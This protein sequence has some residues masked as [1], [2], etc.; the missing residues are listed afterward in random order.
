MN[1]RNSTAGSVTHTLL[2]NTSKSLLENAVYSLVNDLPG[3]PVNRQLTLARKAM[4]HLMSVCPEL[5]YPLD[6]LHQNEL[7]ALFLEGLPIFTGPNAKCCY[8]VTSLMVGSVIGTAYQFEQQHEGALVAAL[9]PEAGSKENTNTTPEHFGWHTD[10]A[11]FL[12]VFRVQ[13]I[14]LTGEINECGAQTGFAP[15]SDLMSQLTRAQVALLSKPIFLFKT[16]ISFAGIDD[17]N[18][19]SEPKSV[20]YQMNSGKTGIQTP[21]YGTKV[22]D[23]SLKEAAD[24][25]LRALIQAAD[26]VAKWVVVREGSYLIFNNERGLH[27]RKKIEGGRRCVHRVY[28][29]RNIE[30]LREATSTDGFVFDANKLLNRS[31]RALDIEEEV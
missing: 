10:D 11:A 14:S 6:K 4:T 29:T 17:L 8:A 9:A 16:P 5:K 12:D 3:M 21:T 2:S 26:E 15:I 22:I 25:A 20:F 24:E 31:A 18:Q 1:A 23:G 13:H 30:T 19:F 28:W 7:D 27:A